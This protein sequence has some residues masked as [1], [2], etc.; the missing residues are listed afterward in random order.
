MKKTLSLLSLLAV[1]VLLFAGCGNDQ[2][3]AAAGDAGQEMAAEPSEFI[4]GNGAEPESLDPHLVSGVPEHRIM[5]AIYEGLIVPDPE[6]AT[7]VP[8]VAESWEI[9]D[10]GTVYT[11]T[12]RDDAVWSDGVPVTAQ[13]FVDS[14][15]RILDPDTAAP[16]AWF[17][18]MFIK[19]A[20]E[21][22]AG[23]AGPEAVAVRAIDDKTFQFETVGPLPYTLDALGHYSFAVVPTQA[24]EEFGSEW[25]LPENFVGNG[26]YTLAEWSPQEQIVLEPNPTYWNAEKVSIDRIVFLPVDDDT[27]A[28]N[29]YLNGEVDWTN[30]IPV[31]QIEQAQLRDDYHA[32]P[33]LG[34]YYYVFNNE[35]E[36]LTDPNVRK[37][38]SMAIDRDLL[39]ETVTKAGQ[40]PAYSMVPEMTG[41]PGIDGLG[42]DVE[43]AQ[44]LLA[45]AGYPGG[46]GFPELTILY[47]TNESHKAIGEFIQQQ[48]LEN[49]GINLTLE[50]QEW[51][52]Y[53]ASRRAGEFD[54]ARAGW[55]G[56]YQDPNTFLDMFITGGAM[57]GG[58]YSNARYDELIEQAAQMSPGPDRFNALTEAETIFIEEDMAVMPIYYYVTLN[59][60]DLSKWAGWYANIMDW[61]P[62]GDIAS[63]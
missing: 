13:Q 2:E 59:M 41:Y 17:P 1:L 21:F 22:N 61:H 26:P 56:D 48:W 32:D 40:V 11:F 20:A 29:M 52:T 31:G 54:V 9:S 12:L 23:E 15:L 3:A 18:S 16:Y 47:N 4:I 30:T 14:W 58:R 10:D 27:T 25:T 62:A 28:H 60:I 55:I 46:E 39:V 51:G 38:L 45:E 6:T 34:T 50:N 8:G 63:M 44:Q 53:L 35:R 49:L 57:N 7:A 37:A 36:P 5:M 43:A 24:I 33:Y 19:G 42:F